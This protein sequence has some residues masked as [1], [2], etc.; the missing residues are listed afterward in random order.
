MKRGWVAV[1]VLACGCGGSFAADP[2][3][4]DAAPE[5]SRDSR[6]EHAVEAG[7][8]APEESSA[9]ESGSPDAAETDARSEACA[10]ATCHDLGSDCGMQNDGCGGKIDCGSCLGAT[11]CGP[12]GQGKQCQPWDGGSYPPCSASTCMHGCC[13]EYGACVPGNTPFACGTAGASC[14][15]CFTQNSYT[16]TSGQCT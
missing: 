2:S 11:S 5:A 1:A 4:T 9:A 12:D 14:Q 7:A 3:T 13:D 16:C 15:F 8:D 6:A 10:P